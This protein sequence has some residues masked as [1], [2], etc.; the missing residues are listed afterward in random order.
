MG[1]KCCSYFNNG[2]FEIQYVK[3]SYI[4][5]ESNIMVTWNALSIYAVEFIRGLPHLDNGSWK[6]HKCTD[7]VQS[8]FD[9]AISSQILKI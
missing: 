9:I 2:Q 4:M 3:L 6:H 5:P 7:L 8:H 1:L